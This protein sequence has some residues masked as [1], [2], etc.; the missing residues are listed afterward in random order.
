LR[1]P[2]ANWPS[3]N[4]SATCRKLAMIKPSGMRASQCPDQF[5]CAACG[6]MQ[7]RRPARQRG[8]PRRQ[9]LNAVD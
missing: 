6:I 9:A 4:P 5:C 7:S 1:S 8:R 2:T 3:C